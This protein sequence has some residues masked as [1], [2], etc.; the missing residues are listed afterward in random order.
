MKFELLTI[1]DTAD[2][3]GQVEQLGHIIKQEQTP[4]EIVYHIQDGAGEHLL[5]N[6]PCGSYLISHGG[7]SDGHPPFLSLDH[8]RPIKRKQNL[9]LS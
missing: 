7:C 9:L 6:T 2:L 1:E 4:N 5:V 3:I 8:L